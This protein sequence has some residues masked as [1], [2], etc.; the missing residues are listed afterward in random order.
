MNIEI[1][2]KKY[3][4]KHVPE[5]ETEVKTEQKTF[6]N[7]IKFRDISANSGGGS[8]EWSQSQLMKNQTSRTA[9]IAKNTMSPG[10]PRT[11]ASSGR[12]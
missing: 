10:Y 7:D 6:D 12:D 9:K 3:T 2:L 11:S 5:I 8:W 4:D 1:R